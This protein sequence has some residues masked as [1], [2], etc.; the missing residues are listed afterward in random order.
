MKT[1]FKLV[2]VFG[3]LLTTCLVTLEL[4]S[5]A[6][7]KVTIPTPAAP[8]VDAVLKCPKCQ[9]SMENGYVPD[10]QGYDSNVVILQWAQGV[11]R[12][13]LGNVK[14]GVQRPIT[15][16]RCTNCGY[17]EMYAR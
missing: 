10:N 14:P 7:H 13:F 6:K 8:E 17:V 9:G 4:A 3:L 16:Y 2:T 5:E 1:W 11:P 15:A 12:K